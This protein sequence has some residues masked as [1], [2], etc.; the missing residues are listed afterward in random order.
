MHYI[1]TKTITWGILAVVIIGVLLLIF[2]PNTTEPYIKNQIE[3]ANYCNVKEDCALAAA[4]K[5]PF[6]CYV[7]VN[8][9]KADTITELIEAY[10]PRNTCEY[11]CLQCLDVEC[12]D[13]KCEPVCS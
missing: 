9:D 11:S 10:V 13:N 6:G 5:C 12:K 4:G 3:K 7:Y 8:K 2:L 1:H